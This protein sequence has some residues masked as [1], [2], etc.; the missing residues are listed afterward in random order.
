MTDVS[1]ESPV[2]GSSARV[3]DVF[4][5]VRSALAIMALLALTVLALEIV[6]HSERVIA[7]VLVAGAIAVLVYPAVEFGA[8]FLP[9]VLVVILLVFLGLGAIGFVSYRLV[10]D[11]TSATD[12]L[13]QAA[14]ARAAQL[15]KN[16]DVLRQVH[17]RRRVKN[18]VDDI[19]K[20]L[21]GGSATKALESAATSGVAFVAGLILTIFF[22]VYG[23]RIFAAGLLQIQ[24]PTRRARVEQVVMRGTRRGLDYARIQVL[25]SLIEGVLAYAIAR[26]AGVPGPAALGVWVGLWTLLPVAGVFVGALPIVLFAGASSLTSAVLVGLAFIAIATAEFIFEP[27]VARDTVEVGSF[28]IVFA[29][30]AGLELDGLT[31]ALLGILGVIVVVAILEEL[32]RE[33]ESDVL[34]PLGKAVSPR[35]E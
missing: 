26:A 19:P 29:A 2:N 25:E 5:S 7:W 33:D 8:R 9:R 16:S 15:E 34:N 3:S 6:R 4:V 28:L 14:P 23:P 20:R 13:Q 1:G 17:L 12:R 30:F 18:L 22:L 27:F 24:N 31:G 32:V 10:N 35:R 11:V 21:T